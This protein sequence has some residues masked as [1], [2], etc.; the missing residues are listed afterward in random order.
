MKLLDI[1][2]FHV[3]ATLDS[4]DVDQFNSHY[5]NMP[6]QYTAIFHGCKYDNFQKKNCDIFFLFLLITLIVCT[7]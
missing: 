4:V 3:K 5:A 2:H 7:C 1:R 6:I